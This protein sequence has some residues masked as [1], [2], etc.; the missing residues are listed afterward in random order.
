MTERRDGARDLEAMKEELIVLQAELDRISNEKTELIRKIV[1]LM[2]E[3]NA[4]DATQ[5]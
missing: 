3:I 1:G 2:R 4:C 5:K